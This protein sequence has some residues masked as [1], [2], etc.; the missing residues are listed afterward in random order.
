[1]YFYS[2]FVG[3]SDRCLSMDTV[4]RRIHYDDNKNGKQL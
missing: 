2:R 1:V 4:K 3:A